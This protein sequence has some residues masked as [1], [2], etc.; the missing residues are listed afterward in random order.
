MQMHHKFSLNKK[1]IV[2]QCNESDRNK[3]KVL[4][5]YLYRKLMNFS[6][7]SLHVVPILYENCLTTPSRYKITKVLKLIALSI[8]P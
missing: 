2:K 4:F 8:I 5:L 3:I 7:R 6:L 1:M